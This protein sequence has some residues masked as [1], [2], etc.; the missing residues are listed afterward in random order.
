MAADDSSSSDAA[1]ETDGASDEVPTEDGA[2]GD[3][4]SQGA[5]A[6]MRQAGLI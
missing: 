2:D 3:D 6:R 4:V 5:F 1:G